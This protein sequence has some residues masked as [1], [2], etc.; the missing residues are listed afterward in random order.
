MKRKQTAALCLVAYGLIQPCLAGSLPTENDVDG[1]LKLCALGNVKSIEGDVKGKIEFWRKGIEGT[2]KGTVSDLGGL[3]A[4]VPNGG[5]A[6]DVQNNYNDCVLNAMRQFVG[7]NEVVACRPSDALLSRLDAA[8]QKVAA[9]DADLAP[10]YKRRDVLQ[11][12][13]DRMPHGCVGN[14]GGMREVIQCADSRDV[15]SDLASTER[16]IARLENEK[17]LAEEAVSRLQGKIC[18]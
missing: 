17:R 14:V 2:G 18:G 6:A 12:Q 5:I 7:G 13:V 11:K 4:T 10:I 15:K 1:I 16:E 8:E 9:I 3:L